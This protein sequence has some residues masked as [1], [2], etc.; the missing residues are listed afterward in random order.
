MKF[1]TP[2]MIDKEEWSI[3]KWLITFKIMIWFALVYHHMKLKSGF[4]PGLQKLNMI[5]MFW[6]LG[7]K[8]QKIMLIKLSGDQQRNQTG[9]GQIML[10]ELKLDAFWVWLLLESF[11]SKTFTL[12]AGSPMPIWCSL[13]LKVLE[14]VWDIKDQL[15]FTIINSTWE[16]LW[17]IQISSG[18]IFPEF[19][20]RTHLCQML[21]E[22]GEQDNSQS[23]ISITRL[24][25]DT[26]WESQDTCLGT[27]PWTSQLCLTL[28]MLVPMSSMEH[29]RETATQSL[30]SSETL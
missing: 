20:Q 13:S 15:C 7:S 14:E 5:L 28:W 10:P 18:G 27:D 9:I 8:I 26:E 6:H 12:D 1:R 11:Q 24:A 19:S 2:M 29:S 4:H 22:S 17:T 3:I 30:D 21:T 25:I 16:L 23:S